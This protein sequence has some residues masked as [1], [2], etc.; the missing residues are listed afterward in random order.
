M[1]QFQSLSHRI[2]GSAFQ[3]HNTL[4]PGYTE[5]VYRNA[6]AQLLSDAGLSVRIE[7]PLTVEFQ[8]RAVGLC[9]ADL[10]VDDILAVE[11]KAQECI[12]PGHQM[13]LRAYLR[14]SGIPAG[15]VVNF[16]PARVDVKRVAA[17]KI[18]KTAG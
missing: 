15:L 2:I 9:L 12:L 16:G 6:L 13:Q 8:G 7:V 14:C 11:T 3:V 18:E 1:F 5:H 10:I 17:G 4:G